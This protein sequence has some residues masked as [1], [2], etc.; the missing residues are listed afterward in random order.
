M[1]VKHSSGTLGEGNQS[2]GQLALP[3]AEKQTT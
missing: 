3:A 2:G 1:K